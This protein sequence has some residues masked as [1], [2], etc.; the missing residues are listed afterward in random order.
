[1]LE[2]FAARRLGIRRWQAA[3]RAR[4]DAIIDRRLK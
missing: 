4:C 1:M 2:D 3:T